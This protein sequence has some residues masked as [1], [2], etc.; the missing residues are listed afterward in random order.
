MKS[1]SA[2]VAHCPAR[3]EIR[4]LG[5]APLGLGESCSGEKGRMNEPWYGI[6]SA[7]LQLINCGRYQRKGDTAAPVKS[8][9]RILDEA[10][11]KAAGKRCAAALYLECESRLTPVPGRSDERTELTRWL[12]SCRWPG[13]IP[14][15]T[16][17][18]HSNTIPAETGL[19]ARLL[20]KRRRSNLVTKSSCVPLA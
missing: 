12:P 16:P 1:R 17:K 3:R 14:I 5:A 10:G 13:N 18:S 7:V 19:R 2:V 20:R 6:L 15:L 8:R 11:G 9:G 4:K